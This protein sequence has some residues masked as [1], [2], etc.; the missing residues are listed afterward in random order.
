M[1]SPGPADG[2]GIAARTSSAPSAW[3]WISSGSITD[4]G[5]G[6]ARM[7]RSSRRAMTRSPRGSVIRLRASSTHSGE[8]SS[9]KRLLMP[10]SLYSV[11]SAASCSAGG[12][13]R[14]LKTMLEYCSLR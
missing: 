3:G 11:R 10:S 2:A 4:S 13:W 12:R 8:T 9:G 5:R 1:V 6:A 14:S 7:A